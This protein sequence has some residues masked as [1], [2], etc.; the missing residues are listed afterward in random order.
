MHPY[1]TPLRENAYNHAKGR[2]GVQFA[3]FVDG[4]APEARPSFLGRDVYSV[5][6]ALIAAAG[7][8]ER[9]GICPTCDGHASLEEYPGQRDEA[10]AWEPIEPPTGEGW[11]YWETVSEGAPISP[12]FATAEGLSRW[13]QTDYHWGSSGPLTKEQADGMVSAGWAPSLI[14]DSTGVHRG[15][16]VA[17]A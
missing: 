4:I 1:L 6:R 12:V 10:E 8:P 3:E 15:D 14:V 9:W 16:E 13:L 2:P 11:Q 5:Q 17:R 7:L